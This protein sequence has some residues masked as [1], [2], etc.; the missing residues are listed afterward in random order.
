M[1]SLRARYAWG[2]L[3]ACMVGPTLLTIAAATA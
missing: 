1:T 2:Y 3:I